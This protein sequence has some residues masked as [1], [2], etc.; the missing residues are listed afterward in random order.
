MNKIR[1]S[2]GNSRSEGFTIEFFEQASVGARN[3][4]LASPFFSDYN[5]IRIL[6]RRGCRVQ[7]LVR[8]CS[9][10]LPSVI[11]EAIQDTNVTLRY[12][13][14][15]E[16][17]AKLYIVDDVALVGSANLTSAGL[18]SNR[19][20]SVVLK[21]ERDPGFDGLPGMFNLLWEYANTMTSEV[22]SSYEQAFRRIG[23]PSEEAEFQK[24]LEGLVPPAAPPT[25][26][27]GSEK[28]SARRSF[29]QLLRR[30]YDE[31]LI[32]AFNETKLVFLAA[33]YRRA[34]FANSDPEIEIGRFLGW[35]RLAKAPGDAWKET[36]LADG[37]HRVS[38]ISGYAKEWAQLPGTTTGDMTNAGAEIEAIERV[39]AAFASEETISGLTYDE[40]FDA[41]SGV[42]A[43]FD[44]LRFTS[45]GLTGLRAE[46]AR[47]NPLSAIKG[48]IS[49]LLHGPG[50]GLERAYDCLYDEKRRL[51]GFGEAC[52]M[53]LLGWMDPGRPPINGRTIKALRFLGHDVRE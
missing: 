5:A 51:A 34:E 53:E 7:L 17:H 38:R 31:E 3:A 33:E 29:I 40:L 52:V 8:L 45:G 2:Y 12:F 18:N 13:T 21:R 49:Y 10:T 37:S 36:S 35:L 47:Q 25:A 32:P 1:D 14:S 30:K 44:R 39:R 43:F 28:V 22:C 4:F 46:F 41:L 11:R 50:L 20:V 9:V 19:E 26:K 27:V 16:F 48:T 42:H 6:T 23:K 24:H 15:R